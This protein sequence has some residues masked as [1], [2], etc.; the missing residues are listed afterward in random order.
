[1]NNGLNILLAEKAPDIHTVGP[2]SSVVDAVRDMN[3]A[4]IG[5]LIVL[6]EDR[7]VGIFTERDVLVRVVA[8]DRD[9]LTTI[10]GD[11]MTRNPVSVSPD[12]S[13]QEAMVLVTEKRFRHLPVV[14]NG[15][16]CGI[17]SSGDLTRWA[18]RDQRFQIDHLSAYI[19]D[20]QMPVASAS[21]FG[22]AE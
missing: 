18:V 21:E 13:V 19:T 22:S 12:M 11:V 3:H 7:V 8:A 9:P 2:D 5:A 16:L 14:R 1:M 4:S 20:T 17:I 10:V 15:R 6:E